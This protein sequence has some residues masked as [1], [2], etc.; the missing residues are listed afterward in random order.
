MFK[1]QV[2]LVLLN[3]HCLTIGFIATLERLK[4]VKGPNFYIYK[5]ERKGLQKAEERS[6]SVFTLRKV[7]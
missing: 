5:Y 7:R 4:K 1:L 3:G 6:S 2:T